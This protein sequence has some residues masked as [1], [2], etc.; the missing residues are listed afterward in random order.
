VVL[1]PLKGM[2]RSSILVFLGIKI[3]KVSSGEST[4][5]DPHV[6]L[7]RLS[8]EDGEDSTCDDEDVPT[9][10]PNLSRRHYFL[11]PVLP[12]NAKTASC[13]RLSLEKLMVN[14]SE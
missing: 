10:W 14:G 11:S 7:W 4:L 9:L 3:Y 5:C 13:R 1:E 8:N 12:A 2:V 6:P